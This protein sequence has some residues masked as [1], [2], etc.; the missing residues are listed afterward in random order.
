MQVKFKAGM[1]GLDFEAREHEQ[2]RAAASTATCLLPPLLPACCLL[3]SGIYSVCHSVCLSPHPAFLSAC[4]PLALSASDL[5]LRSSHSVCFSR[6][7]PLTLPASRSVC[8]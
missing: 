4:L 8:L 7:L 3:P 6:L 1:F 5:T 2:V